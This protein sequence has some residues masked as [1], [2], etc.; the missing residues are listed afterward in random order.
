[1]NPGQTNPACTHMKLSQW[2]RGLFV[3]AGF[4]VATAV[5]AAPFLPTDDAQVLERLPSRSTPQF[6]DLKTLQAAAASAPGDLT[7]A[8]ALAT[9]YIRASRVEGDPRFLGYA[10][11]ALAPWWK[12]PEAPTRVLVLRATILQ[13]SH[14]FAAAQADLDRVLQREPRNV[15]AILTRA[16]ILT[17]RGDFAAARPDCERL[18]GLA[19]PIYRGDLSRRD[20]QRDRQGRHRV[21]RAASVRCNLRRA[22]TTPGASGPKRCSAKLRTVGATP[23]RSGTSAQRLVPAPRTRICWVRMPIGCSIRIDRPTCSPCCGPRTAIDTLLLR[24]ALAQHALAR[25]EAAA[26]IETLRA[27][28]DASH[29]RGDTVH[30]RE[31]ARFELA[32]RNDARS[33]LAAMPSTAGRCSA[34]RPTCGFLRRPRPQPTTLPRCGRCSDGWQRPASSTRPSRRW[35]AARNRRNEAVVRTLRRRSWPRLGATGTCAQA[36]RQLSIAQGRRRAHQR[37]VGHRPARPGFRG[38][39]RR[40]SGRRDHLGRGQGEAARISR[41]TRCRGCASDLPRRP[42]LRRSTNN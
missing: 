11:A 40:E 32:L 14:Q 24:V 30:A 13:S 28:F 27:R 36:V 35:Q 2:S 20:R 4:G 3:V 41:H 21:R 37:A 6:R 15:Q 23:P 26:S 38:R 25:P 12:D 33:A 7:R 5:V 19:P 1:M 16:T 31:N 8:L 22:S 9:A 17:V 42:A 10:Q 18:D 39:P 29:A 34:S